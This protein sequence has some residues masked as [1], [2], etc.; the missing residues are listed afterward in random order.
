MSNQFTD[1]KSIVNQD[2]TSEKDKEILK[3]LPVF[4]HTVDGKRLDE[5]KLDGLMEF[6]KRS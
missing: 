1:L 5:E 6:I 4:I 3:N 2:I